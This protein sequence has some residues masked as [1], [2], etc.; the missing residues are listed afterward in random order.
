MSQNE[1]KEL[2][3]SKCPHLKHIYTG[4]G[5]CNPSFFLQESPIIKPFSEKFGFYISL[6]FR[7]NP[8]V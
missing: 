1:I 7:P 8:K 4:W 2:S 5:G 6:D 3:I